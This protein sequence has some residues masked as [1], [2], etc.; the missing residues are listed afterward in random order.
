[1]HLLLMSDGT[2]TNDTRGVPWRWLVLGLCAAVTG[3]ILARSFF[4]VDESEYVFVT[5]F[6]QPI[7]FHAQPG[8]Q[9]KWPYQSLL[10]FDRRLQVFEPP[11]REMLTQDKENLT[12]AWYVCWRLPGDAFAN[13]HASNSA[14]EAERSSL[15]NLVTRFLQSA[16]S[17][18]IMESRLEERVQAAMAAEIGRL[19]FDQLVALDAAQ[20]D[21]N[22][23]AE[24]VTSDMR[25]AAAEQFGIEVVDIRLKRITYPEAVQ[26]AVYAEI[27]SERQRVAV[28]YRAEGASEKAKIQSL[29]DLQRDQLLARARGEALAIRGAGEAKAI[30]IFNEA[31]S[32]NPAFYELLKTLETYRNIL[33]EQTTVVLSA[34]S[35]LLKLLTRGL[36]A[37]G[38]RFAV[39]PPRDAPS[40]ASE[41]P[42]ADRI[43]TTA[44]TSAAAETQP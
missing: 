26:P 37:T 22:G 32:R 36:P 10:R 12:F 25:R 44:T 1:M 20:L 6:G 23:L 8:L 4:F 42:A 15:E 16:G 21:W 14:G 29:A 17:A 38:E 18:D 35:P 13:A 19:R 41:E 34:D 7:R 27:R 5:Q 11:A 2:T 39:P 33:D 31:H 28:Q 24:R 30:E 9:F 40:H 43:D 3:L